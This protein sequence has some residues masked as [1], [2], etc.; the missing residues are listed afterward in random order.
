MGV[1]SF[2]TIVIIFLLW[3]GGMVGGIITDY[4]LPDDELGQII[5]DEQ[6]GTGKTKYASFDKGSKVVECEEQLVKQTLPFDGGH[7]Q[8]TKQG[9][10]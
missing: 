10:G 3:T 8:L 1:G 2:I 5:C 9:G 6:Y 4:V 7:T